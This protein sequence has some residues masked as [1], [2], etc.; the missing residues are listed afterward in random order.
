MI[1]TLPCIVCSG[2]EVCQDCEKDGTSQHHLQASKKKLALQSPYFHAMFYGGFSEGTK[3]HIKL[4]GIKFSA[5]KHIINNEELS[6]DS[7]TMSFDIVFNILEAAAMLQFGRIQKQCCRFLINSMTV[8]NV[9]EILGV[10]EHLSIQELFSKAFAFI[11]YHFEKIAKTQG[12]ANLEANTLKNIVK[13]TH[14]KVA[15]E[16]LVHDAIMRWIKMDEDSRTEHS[17]ELLVNSEANQE[18][19]ITDSSF[20]LN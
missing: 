5:L 11:L 19:S 13:S 12:F 18:Q 16:T 6:V 7:R 10:A 9:I 4:E 20:S 2:D 15:N 8:I 1:C 14:L 3:S 17:S